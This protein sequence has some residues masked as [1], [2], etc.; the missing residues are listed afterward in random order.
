MRLGG[1]QV[2]EGRIAAC[3]AAE[4]LHAVR[5]RLAELAVEQV[6]DELL[7]RPLALLRQK[8]RVARQQ[9]P[10]VQT[11][12]G[13]LLRPD[14]IDGLGVLHL[15]EQERELRECQLAR[16]QQPLARHLPAQ[17]GQQCA[18]VKGLAL[19]LRPQA[20]AVCREQELNRLLA[21][22]SEA[23]ELQL[24]THDEEARMHRADP[25][26]CIFP[27]REDQAAEAVLAQEGAALI[28]R[29]MERMR[30]VCLRV[31][32]PA[33]LLTKGAFKRIIIRGRRRI[34]VDFPTAAARV[35]APIG[36]ADESV[37][38][39]GPD[40]DDFPRLIAIAPII[41]IVHIIHSAYRSRASS[42]SRSAAGRRSRRP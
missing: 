12:S 22:Q 9:L 5:I 15:R 13:E 29:Q 32:V 35:L 34:D 19:A 17:E 20:Q 41:H 31:D 30:A 8:L 11:Q 42:S 38:K 24:P 21:G 25:A 3:V 33:Q 7:C 23:R 28:L 36:L 1:Q 27:E 14:R 2:D 10:A 40:C 26:E 6:R 16:R 18:K 4:R 37:R 39:V